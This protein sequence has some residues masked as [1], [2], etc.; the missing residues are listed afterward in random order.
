MADNT[1][2][3]PL[4]ATFGLFTGEVAVGNFQRKRRAG[5]AHHVRGK[6]VGV[7]HGDI[8]FPTFTL[9]IKLTNFSGAVDAAGG[10]SISPHDVFNRDGA[11]A[12]AV[13]T[14]A[15]NLGGGD[16]FCVDV[17]LAGEGTDIGE[18][19]DHSITL[20][21]VHGVPSFSFSGEDAMWTIE[22]TVYGDI[23]G[24]ITSLTQPTLA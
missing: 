3:T 21:A 9:T 23:T 2:S 15:V 7:R 12:A 1:P 17:T 19:S 6:F 16:V 10:T 11:W 8:E 24:D 5:I 20:G 22:C 14:L 13:S 18:G 4:S